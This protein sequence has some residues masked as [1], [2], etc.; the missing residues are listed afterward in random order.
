MDGHRSTLEYRTRLTGLLAH[1]LAIWH[2]IA[3]A[4]KFSWVLHLLKPTNEAQALVEGLSKA[5]TREKMR[6]QQP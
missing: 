6:P 1:L 3:E 2:V 4:K 5:E